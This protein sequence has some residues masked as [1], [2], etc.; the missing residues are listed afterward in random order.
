MWKCTRRK[1]LFEYSMQQF[2]FNYKKIDSFIFVNIQA[3]I[4]DILITY[5]GIIERFIKESKQFVDINHKI[6]Y[7]FNK[8]ILNL[9]LY[10]DG[11]KVQKALRPVFGLL[12][13]VFWNNHQL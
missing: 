11:V 7:D 6:N 4:K 5:F 8:L 2:Q 12:F 10:I 1:T 9:L 3:Q 13:V